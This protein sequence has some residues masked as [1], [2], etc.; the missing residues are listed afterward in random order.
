MTELRLYADRAGLHDGTPWALLN[1]NGQVQVDGHG[2]S[3]VPK[4]DSIL[5]VVSD[6]CISVISLPLPDLPL[7]RLKQALPTII[8]DHL[9]TAIEA[10]ETTLIAPPSNGV[11]T[12]AAFSRDWMASLLLAPT[13]AR[14]PVVRVVAES[15]GLPR[16]ESEP[17]I[18]VGADH[19]V[20]A[21]HE[22]MAFTEPTP[23]GTAKPEAILFALRQASSGDKRLT[24]IACFFAPEMVGQPPIW[25]SEFGIA[26]DARGIFDWRTASFNAA[27][28]L[29]VRQ[30]KAFPFAA[31]KQS[32]RPVAAVVG[33]LIAFEI[34]ATA[35]AFGRLSFENADL[36]SRQVAM[37]RAVM[38][39]D[40]TL[41]DGERQLIHRLASERISAGRAEPADLLVLMSRIAE[42]ASSAPALDE[43]RFES[44]V[45]SLQ[46]KTRED[47][48][49]WLD[50]AR[51]ADLAATA[52]TRDGKNLIRVLP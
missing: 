23:S 19:I 20:L 35:V 52:E 13:I 50:L 21:M 29:H 38:G 14:C 12:L 36:K 5:I 17:S 43:M 6:D 45:L 27:P 32:I 42:N 2:I 39:P 40:A 22:W 30:R 4:A 49:V 16:L 44:G 33:A 26:V 34:F 10:T 28:N 15:W 8:E 9:L 51:S 18:Y 48:A 24:G 31:L 11:G 37:F 41:V 1:G 47:L 25:L 7:K 46:A 3:S